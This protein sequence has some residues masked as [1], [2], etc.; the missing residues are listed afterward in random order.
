MSKKIIYL[1][2]LLMALSIA[3][4]SCKKTTAPGGAGGAGGAGGDGPIPKTTIEIQ[5][6]YIVVNFE[7]SALTDRKIEFRA[8]GTT[9]DIS[10]NAGKDIVIQITSP[11]QKISVNPGSGYNIQIADITSETEKILYETNNITT[12]LFYEEFNQNEALPANSEQ[13]DNLEP[14]KGKWVAAWKG[15]AAWNHAMNGSFRNLEL[16]KEGNIEYL[17]MRGTKTGDDDSTSKGSGMQTTHLYGT[18]EAPEDSKRREP[19]FFTYGKVEFRAR[20]ESQVGK[21]KKGPFPALWLMPAR[22]DD[23]QRPKWREWAAGGEIDVMEYV[24][25]DP[26]NVDQTIHVGHEASGEYKGGKGGK[27]AVA[28]INDWHT[29]TLEWTKEGLY[30]YVDG[31]KGRGPYLKA[32]KSAVDYPFLDKSAF[33]MIINVGVGRA[34]NNGKEDNYPGGAQKGLDTWMDVDWV[35]VSPNKD[36]ILDNSRGVN[37]CEYYKD[38][39]W[40]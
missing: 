16:K 38:V 39:Q 23:Q 17:H 21:Q 28:N 22:G 29:Y 33:Y 9:T 37:G 19:F 4:T 32:G 40:K 18:H 2:S 35:K 27:A 5:D 20:I 26:N 6:K 31:Q 15:K 7:E 13:P 14:W 1:L 8:I 30:W 34:N 3:F 25:G 24:W 12:Y 11:S 10:A 36:T